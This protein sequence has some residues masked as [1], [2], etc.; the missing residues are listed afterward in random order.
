MNFFTIYL[1]EK[2]FNSKKNFFVYFPYY[3]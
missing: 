3:F 2:K 1:P